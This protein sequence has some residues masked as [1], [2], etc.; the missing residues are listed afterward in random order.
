MEY[1]LRKA[2]QDDVK[3]LLKL[4]RMTMDSYLANHGLDISDAEHLSR[5]QYKFE[6]ARI[7]QV[8]TQNMGL[9]KAKYLPEKL[10][11]YIFQIQ[12][13]P[14]YQGQGIGRGLITNLCEKA[15]KENLSVGLSV[16]KS[17]PAKKLYDALGFRVVAENSA[18]YDMVYDAQ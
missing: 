6:A 3:F 2:N 15:N 13:L 11:W 9:F 7:V 8:D 16:L 4:R 5:I 18:E 12:I 14:S 17:N 10:Q 1:S